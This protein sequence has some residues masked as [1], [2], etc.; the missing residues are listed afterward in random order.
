MERPTG[1]GYL[2][3][4]YGGEVMVVSPTRLRL[5]GPLETGGRSIRSR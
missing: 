2:R 4:Y 5:L 3:Y 1:S